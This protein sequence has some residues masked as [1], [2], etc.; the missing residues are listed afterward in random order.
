MYLEKN[1]GA[2]FPSQW[3]WIQANTFQSDFCVTSTAGRRG[4]PLMGEEE[5][6][7]LVALHWNGEFLPFPNVK[8]D[9]RWGEWNIFGRYNEYTV[10][11]TGVCDDEG[12]PVDCPTS[13]G[14]QS[15]AKET[16]H[17]QLRVQLYKRNTLVLDETTDEA[18]LEVGGLPWMCKSWESESQM[19]E[20]IKSIAMNVQLENK[21]SDLLEAASLFIDIPGL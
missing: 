8:W 11:L 7:G 21:V 1:W 15:I 9:V 18:C 12:F 19:K 5:E 13:S 14:M 17:G 4:I 3:W 16:F 2:S 6:V 20:P 10:K